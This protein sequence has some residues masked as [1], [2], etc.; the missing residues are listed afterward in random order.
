MILTLKA[1][2][3]FKIEILQPYTSNSM[4]WPLSAFFA[5]LTATFSHSH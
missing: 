4:G 1:L 3:P 2:T 5:T